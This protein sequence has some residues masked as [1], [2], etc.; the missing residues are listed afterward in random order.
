MAGGRVKLLPAEA[1]KLGSDYNSG[2]FAIR[3]TVAPHRNWTLTLF[4]ALGSATESRFM[5]SL[6]FKF[7]MLILVLM[8]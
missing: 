4:S 5:M 1:R 2:Q 8:D 6:C 7:Q 3:R